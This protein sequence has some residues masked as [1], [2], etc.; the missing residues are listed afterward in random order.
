MAKLQEDTGEPV[1]SSKRPTA[2]DA[3]SLTTK[4]R[5]TTPKNP[6]YEQ[7]LIGVAF[8]AGSGT[9]DA[10]TLDPRLGKTFEQVV[11]EFRE[12]AGFV[13]TPLN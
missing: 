6:Q 2:V 3:K 8:T 4:Y 12:M 1:T 13:L 7:R 11:Q 5:I 9:L 10:D